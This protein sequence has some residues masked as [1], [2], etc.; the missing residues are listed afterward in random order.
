LSSGFLKKIW[1]RDWRFNLENEFEKPYV[2]PI[3][4]FAHAEIVIDLSEFWKK[5]MSKEDYEKWQAEIRIKKMVS[6]AE[7]AANFKIIMQR[8]QKAILQGLKNTFE[9]TEKLIKLVKESHLN[10]KYRGAIEC[11][12]NGLKHIRRH[13]FLEAHYHKIDK[14][15]K[16][17]N[18][19]LA[20]I[21]AY[22]YNDEVC[23]PEGFFSMHNYLS[24]KIRANYAKRNEN[25]KFLDIAIQACEE[26]I[27]F[28]KNLSKKV[29][30]GVKQFTLKS[31]NE[32]TDD[33]NKEL[34]NKYN[35]KK[36]KGFNPLIHKSPDDFKM[37]PGKLGEHTGYKQLCIIREKQGNWQEVIRLAEQAKAEGWEGDWDKRIE[38]AKK[39]LK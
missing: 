21:N 3:P 16:E 10:K 31:A 11:R 19:L 35:G 15:I 6:E 34:W 29:R 37:L 4:E 28:A 26:Q 9:D 5:I 14:K 12:I 1:Q 33:F 24:G 36:P 2:S 18:L 32:I 39:K 7:R 17:L 22:W 13:D 23:I 30:K 20:L 27:A 8:Y 25:Q 38:K